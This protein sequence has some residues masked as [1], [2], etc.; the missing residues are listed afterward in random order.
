MLTH[1]FHSL[2]YLL[3]LLITLPL[4][5][6]CPG[7]GG[8][9]SN[10]GD[11]STATKVAKVQLTVINNYQPADG[12]TF[13]NVAVTVRDANNAS[14]PN[15]AINMVS[16]SPNALFYAD[17]DETDERGIFTAGFS[18]MVAE[19]IEVTAVAEGVNSLP[20]KLTFIA[21]TSAIELT[22]KQQFAQ[23]GESIELTVLTRQNLLQLGNTTADN[24]QAVLVP[25]PNAPLKIAV[26]GAASFSATPPTTTDETGQATFII[27][28][29]QAETIVVTVSSGVVTQ[30]LPLYIGASL[31]LIPA[32]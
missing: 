5:T 8:G 25:L 14:L 19:T 26:S 4:L 29:K 23:K 10:T 6:G 7:G 15:I 13:I 32:S 1:I 17:L 18:D 31:T 24:T 22:T 28:D 16:N 2:H 9:A 12:N 21:P 11:T 3:L 30:T 27:S 20:M